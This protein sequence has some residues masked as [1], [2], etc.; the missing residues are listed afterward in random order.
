[1]TSG[2]GGAILGQLTVPPGQG[3]VVL[4]SLY[5]DSFLC[6]PCPGQKVMPAGRVVSPQA[7][8]G[9]PWHSGGEWSWGPL[10]GSA[11]GREG[12]SPAAGVPGGDVAESQ[13]L[14]PQ[15]C[16]SRKGRGPTPAP[17]APVKSSANSCRV[18]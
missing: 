5:P 3:T 10:L 16:G 15:G 12:G 13:S 11:W 6:C 2:Q 14:N 9:R 7:S 4:A 1:M 17:P 18:N 8:A